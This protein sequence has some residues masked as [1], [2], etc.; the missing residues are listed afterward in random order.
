MLFLYSCATAYRW[1]D[2]N[3]KGVARSLCNS[4]VSCCA[5]YRIQRLHVVQLVA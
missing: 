4:C 3:W 1:P 5:L 2:F